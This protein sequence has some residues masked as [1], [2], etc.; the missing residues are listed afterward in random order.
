MLYIHC[1]ACV[2]RVVLSAVQYNHVL[3]A[4][5]SDWVPAMDRVRS[6]VQYSNITG[7]FH[8]GIIPPVFSM[9]PRLE[10]TFQLR[11]SAIFI[12]AERN[13]ATT[14]RKRSQTR[15]NPIERDFQNGVFY[16]NKLS[17]PNLL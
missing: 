9:A 7:D 1:T 17:L 6:I 12:D 5:S 2:F 16:Q 15:R 3:L 8:Q 14:D 4:E 13:D 11:G 10:F